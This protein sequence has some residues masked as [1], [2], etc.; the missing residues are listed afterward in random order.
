MAR[1]VKAIIEMGEDGLFSA[2]SDFEIEGYSFGGFGDNANEA[3]DD[4]MNS[5][6]EAIELLR[7]DGKCDF[8]LEDFEVEW[9]YDIPSMFGCFEYLN[10][11][12]FAEVAGVNS[13]KM[14]QYARGIAYP[15]EKT[16][17]KISDAIKAVSRDLSMIR[18]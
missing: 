6:K 16:M 14:R 5:I 13:S 12:K 9:K 15:S 1:K 18:L 7:E 11:S 10:I 3:K 8:I 4:F 17:R 2:Y